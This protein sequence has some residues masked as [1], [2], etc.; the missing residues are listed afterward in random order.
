MQLIYNIAV[1]VKHFFNYLLADVF[2]LFFLSN[3]NGSP[4]KEKK[5]HKPLLVARLQSLSV[6][7]QPPLGPR[8]PRQQPHRPQRAR[9]VAGPRHRP[10]PARPRRLPLR[11]PAGL[12]YPHAW[13]LQLRLVRVRSRPNQPRQFSPL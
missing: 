11:L 4:E 2:A 13:P 1:F 10:D 12:H 9:R 6:G 5:E 8:R 3:L 7:S